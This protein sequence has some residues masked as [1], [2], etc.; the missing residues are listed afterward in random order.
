MT[1]LAGI[2]GSYVLQ[3]DKIV[4]KPE[5]QDLRASQRKEAMLRAVKVTSPETIDRL[6]ALRPSYSQIVQ[7]CADRCGTTVERVW[8]GRKSRSISLAKH[9]AWYLA[10]AVLLESLHEIGDRHG[11]HHTSVHHGVSRI[12]RA[13]AYDPQISQVVYDVMES[14]EGR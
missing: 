4:F 2:N 14:L 3:G 10:K 5:K 1:Q 9:V 7:S 13:I 6:V 8:S 11:A 12:A